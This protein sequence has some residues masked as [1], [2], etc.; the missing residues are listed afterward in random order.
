MQLGMAIDKQ[1]CIGCHT[2]SV[3]CRIE[4]NL[5]IGMWW[6]R[7][8]TDGG[9]D[10]D[11]PSGT[12]PNVDMKYYTLA[13]Q[14]CAMPTCFAVCPVD[15]I[16]KREEDGLVVQDNEKCIGCKLCIDACPYTGVRTFLEEE[17][18]YVID[19]AVGSPYAAPHVKNTVDKCTLCKHRIDRG[20]QPACIKVCLAR[21]RTFGDIGDP[22]S[23]ISQL[24]ASRT[25]HQL[26]PEKG[27][28]PSVYFLD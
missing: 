1:R 6:N 8:I 7:T 19:F 28:N 26:L 22:E 10:M 5:P 23:D 3:A 16:I 13:C 20:E 11:T 18:A 24:I 14:H 9:T 21:A 2:C 25:S 15:A 12:F 27:T 4:N 17:P